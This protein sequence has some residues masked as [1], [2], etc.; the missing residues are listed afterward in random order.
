MQRPRYEFGML[1]V[2]I[3]S[4]FLST[5]GIML[6][7]VE[8]AD[9]WQILFYRGLAFSFVL[10]LILLFRYRRRTLGAFRAIGRRGL[11]AAL[12]LGLG[13]CCYI[14]ALLFTTVANAV[15]II[16]AAPLVT[17]FAAWLVLH[18]RTPVFGVV[19]MLVSL[20][21]VGLMFA[22]GLIAGR[23]LGNL[24]ALLTVASF[25][26]YLLL[27]RGAG[28]TDMLPATCLGGIVMAVAGLMGAVHLSVSNHDLL[29]ALIMGSV[30]FMVG[31]M[32]FTVAA[33]Y[34]L[35]S[36]VALFALAESILAPVW[37]WIGVGE[38]PSGITLLGSA[39]VLLSV[40]VYCGVEIARQRR[41]AAFESSVLCPIPDIK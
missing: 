3:G 22:D 34:M 4:V 10:S 31:F 28:D 18:E 21:G 19:A 20:V 40:G 17:A 2:I 32:C 37:V 13:S 14:F 26:T 24:M 33:R 5:N 16:G 30:Q 25:A 1:L 12:V 7:S 6:R 11:W 39:V 27:L 38:I 29:I 8:Q 15:F 35:A 23:W 9:G 36:E 41:M